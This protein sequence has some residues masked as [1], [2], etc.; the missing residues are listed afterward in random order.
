MID[1][2][3]APIDQRS[4]GGMLRD[5]MM[6]DLS[7]TLR[8]V[9][10]R[11]SRYRQQAIGEQNT[12]SILIEPVL[13][14][15]GWDIE[16]FE[17]VQRE[18]KP[19]PTDNPVDYALFII[20]TPRLFIEAKSLGGNLDDRRW[21]NQIMGYA[22]VTGVEWVVL[23]D[24][25]E[26]RV[27]NS[28]APVPIEEKLFRSVRIDGDGAPVAETLDLLSKAQMQENLIEALWKSHFV[29]R[30]IRAMIESLFGPDPDPAFIRFIRNRMPRLSPSEIKAA[31]TRVRV[32]L[33][34]P[35]VP[36][37]V[38]KPLTSSDPDPSELGRPSSSSE[39]QENG[40]G[41]PWRDVK[42]QDLIEAGL[43]HPPL[44]LQ[45][46]YKGHRFVG[47]ITPEGRF[48]WQGQEFNSP[49]TAA[50]TARASI[51]GSRPGRKYPQTN[52]WT[53]W[54]FV[55]ADGQAKPL[56]VLRQRYHASR[57]HAG[58]AASNPVES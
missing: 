52:G 20:R 10:E 56:D 31:L 25:D 32:R 50:G 6:N 30:Q 9:R 21:A 51:V 24:G 18:Y 48:S 40:G 37:F 44:E 55:D 38:P 47:R 28:H 23:T 34:F 4:R 54:Q 13:R 14:A 19:K 15:L 36:E 53:F 11:I 7:N 29:D 58:P 49:S 41:T 45:R 1:V 5:E 57:T 39:R 12:K 33:D 46:T 3:L 22:A 42:L 43:V 35:T 16:D 26:Y 8:Q 17:E 27:Y 2:L